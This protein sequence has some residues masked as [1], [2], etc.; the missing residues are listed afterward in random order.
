MEWQNF[1][2]FHASEFALHIRQKVYPST[3]EAMQILFVT[4]VL[5]VSVFGVTC[6]GKI[7]NPVEFSFRRV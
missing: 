3:M 2:E 4:F 6:P 7:H 1:S 5:R